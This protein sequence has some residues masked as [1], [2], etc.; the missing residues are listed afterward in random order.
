MNYRDELVTCSE[1][2]K[3][4]VFT[5]EKQRKMADRGLEVVAPDLCDA[6][7]PATPDAD[8]ERAHD[9]GQLLGHIKWFNPEKGYGFLVQEDGS[10]LF[11]HRSSVAPTADGAPPA[12]AEGQEV[13]YEVG[14]TPKGPQALQV[15]PYP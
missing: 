8:R 12:L 7:T 3:Q 4:S 2:G 14:D 10:E 9:G 13:L 6:C 11:V 15:T 5:V 1:C